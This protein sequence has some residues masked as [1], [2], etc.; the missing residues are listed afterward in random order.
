MDEARR[1]LDMDVLDIMLLHEQE[2]QTCQTS[3]LTAGRGPGTGSDSG[4]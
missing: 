2:A 3:A 1:Q 4:R